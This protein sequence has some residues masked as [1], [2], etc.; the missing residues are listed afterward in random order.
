MITAAAPSPLT[1]AQE[2]RV[3]ELADQTVA[4]FLAA[5]VPGY[6][7]PATGKPVTYATAIKRGLTAYPYVISG[8]PLE[9]RV[10]AAEKK[11]TEQAV[12]ILA[13]TGKV[14]AVELLEQ[15][16]AAEQDDI[17]ASLAQPIRPAGGTA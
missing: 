17:E 7:D 4:K 15:S 3:R 12:N 8:G 9:K 11:L 6:T 5:P 14:A 16:Q 1:P 13:V 2:T 10:T